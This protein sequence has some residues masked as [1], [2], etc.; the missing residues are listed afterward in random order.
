VADLVPVFDLDGTL[1]DSDRA[2]IEPFLALGVPEERVTFGL[3]L[4]EACRREGI[5]V[6]TYL[7]AY[8]GS[9]VA[10]F[11][12]VDELVRALPRW[13]VCSNKLGRAGRAELAELGWEPDVAM[14]VED[15]GGPKG[16]GPVLDALEV[17]A[18]AVVFV[19]DS[20]HDRACA[21]DAGARFALAAWNARV[22]PSAGDVVLR[23]PG[24]LLDVLR[25][26]G[27]R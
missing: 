8:D 1:L 27:D 9:A 7:A 10:P 16:L 15:F 22:T 11:P 17:D 5:T 23:E 13:A 20:E 24:D 25:G 26:A 3:T 6:E 19:G 12:G 14:F 2:L 18:G 21:R 4:E